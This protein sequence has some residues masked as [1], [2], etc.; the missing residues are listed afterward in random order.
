MIL[1]NT[2]KFD[3]NKKI[4]CIISAIQEYYPIFING[5]TKNQLMNKKQSYQYNDLE[6]YQ[7]NYLKRFL[8]QKNFVSKK[9][10]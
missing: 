10:N 2:I 7:I 5:I 4:I 3:N 6:N 8:F 9:I 1:K